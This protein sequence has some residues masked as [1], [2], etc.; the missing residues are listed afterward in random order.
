LE[1]MINVRLGLSRKDDR[2][3]ERFTTEPLAVHA[4]TCDETGEGTV[5]SKE[6]V[7]FGRI[8][9]F[10]AMLDRYYSLR[11]WDHQGIPTSQTLNRLGLA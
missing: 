9:D 6:P 1:R 11:G 3:P 10:D 8:T 5:R 2:L 4:Y 7:H